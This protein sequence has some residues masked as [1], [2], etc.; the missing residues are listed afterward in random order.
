LRRSGHSPVRDDRD[1]VALQRADGLGA[2]PAT[3]VDHD[4]AVIPPGPH[5]HGG[6][7]AALLAC[8]AGLAFER[9]IPAAIAAAS[10]V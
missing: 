7:I 3:D 1:T 6:D 9:G 4:G 8:L 10:T 5:H 2:P